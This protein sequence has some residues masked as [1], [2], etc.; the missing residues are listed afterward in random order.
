MLIVRQNKMKRLLIFA[1]WF[2][3]IWGGVALI[4]VLAIGGFFAYHFAYGNRNRIDSASPRDVRFVLN[5]CKLGENRIEKVVHSYVS[6]RSF[7]GDHPDAY[8]IKITHLDVKE[9]A[10][11]KDDSEDHWYQGDGLH[12]VLDEAI[13]FVGGFVNSG[14]VP[15]FPD[16][17]DLRSS[18]FYIYPVTI[19]CYGLRTTAAEIIFVKPSEKMVYYFSGKT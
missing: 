17:K 14:E 11:G 5:W 4:A 18:E 6:S 13:A 1:K 2:L 19:H 12:K 15:W 7:T 9:L 8:A 16:E 3:M 10:A